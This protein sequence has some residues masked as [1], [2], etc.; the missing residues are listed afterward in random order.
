VRDV[1][2]VRDVMDHL[3]MAFDVGKLRQLVLLKPYEL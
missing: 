3:D 2:V 1:L